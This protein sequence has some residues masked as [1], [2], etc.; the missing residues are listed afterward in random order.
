LIVP[1]GEVVLRAACAQHQAWRDAGFP[2]FPISVNLSARQFRQA[3]LKDAI[4]R[5]VHEAGL[6]PAM[7]E[8]E[9]T[10]SLL[11][12]HTDRTVETLDHLHA[13]G[14]RLSI[15]DFGVGYSSLS[16]LK[17]F[18]IQ[19][20]KIDQSFMRH[21]TSDADDAAIST[22]IIA[23]AHGLKLRVVAEG[24][25]TEDQLAFLMAK[26]CD[27]VQGY[28]FSRPLPADAMTALLE[29][30]QGIVK[31][32]QGSSGRNDPPIRRAA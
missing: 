32:A 9:L 31:P 17:R 30:G 10:E 7:L 26:G 27:A 29:T 1:I 3:D 14:V 4:A 23:M 12:D 8:L 13:M 20:L 22:A 24:V 5:I 18:P 15:D 16:Y 28:L 11:M 19:T 6:D 2:S 25:E 21:V